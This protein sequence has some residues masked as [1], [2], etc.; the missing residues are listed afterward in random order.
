MCYDGLESKYLWEE[1]WFGYEDEE[2]RMT[3]GEVLSELKKLVDNLRMYGF[4]S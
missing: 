2:Y 1:I 3:L 4:E